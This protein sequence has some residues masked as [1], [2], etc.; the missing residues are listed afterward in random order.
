M[1]VV[2]NKPAP[3]KKKVA[4]QEKRKEQIKKVEVKA[5]EAYKEKHKDEAKKSE[6]R[7]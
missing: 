5:K 1:K 3:L 2:K 4:F 6:Q 7:V